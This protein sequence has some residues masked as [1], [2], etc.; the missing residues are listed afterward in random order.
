MATQLRYITNNDEMR[1]LITSVARDVKDDQILFN[2]IRKRFNLASLRRSLQVK[3][4]DD[5]DIMRGGQFLDKDALKSKPTSLEVDFKK[6]HAPD[7]ISRIIE[8]NNQRLTLLKNVAIVIEKYFDTKDAIVI[9][10]RD[11]IKET[12]ETIDKVVNDATN[13]L[14]TKYEQILPPAFK[15][16]T[17]KLRSWF[18]RA[19]LKFSKLDSHYQVEQHTRGTTYMVMYELSDLHVRGTKLDYYVAISGL[20]QDDKNFRYYIGI[21]NR[22]FTAGQVRQFG[23]GE[24]FGNI[25]HALNILRGEFGLKEK[26]D[27]SRHGNKIAPRV[28]MRDPDGSGIYEPFQARGREKVPNIPVGLDREH[29]KQLNKFKLD[30][31][32]TKFEI[33]TTKS[34]DAAAAK[35]MFV[36][37]FAALKEWNK[38]YGLLFELKGNEPAGRTQFTFSYV[39]KRKSPKPLRE[40]AIPALMN[41]FGYGVNLKDTYQNE[42]QKFKAVMT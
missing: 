27:S 34:V 39:L 7:K 21:F 29:V 33:I 24:Q 36:K 37:C 11:L 3:A 35:T 23:Y 17:D 31:D 5:F 2:A 22:P 26:G 20:T 40:G 1:R 14:S 8:Q 41:V 28:T 15:A 4:A 9:R 32:R 12:Q 13:L 25:D 10:L 16:Y 42:Q 38:R 30:K 19:G 6:L 18:S